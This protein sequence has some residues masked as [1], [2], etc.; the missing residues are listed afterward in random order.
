MEVVPFAVE[1]PC[2]L[3]RPKYGREAKAALSTE[4]RWVFSAFGATNE[5]D[6]VLFAFEKVLVKEVLRLRGARKAFPA[7]KRSDLFAVAAS[8]RLPTTS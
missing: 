5:G 7:F 2:V 4:C 1:V 8:V 3:L 6:R